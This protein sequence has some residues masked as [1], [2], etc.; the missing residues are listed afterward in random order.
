MNVLLVED[1]PGDAR[2]LDLMLQEALPDYSLTHA[3]SL[4]EAFPLVREGR[5]DVILLD[6]SLPDAS[7]HQTFWQ[8]HSVAFSTPII[9]MTGLDDEALAAE[10][11]QAGAQ[12]FLV[13]GTVDARVLQRAMRYAIERKRAESQ[14]RLA[15]RVFES[16]MEGILI[17][18]VGGRI[19]AANDA[20]CKITGHAEGDIVGKSLG[21]LWEG[22]DHDEVMQVVRA[23][24]ENNGKWQGEACLR[25]K[26]GQ[27]FPAWLGANAVL[28]A[29]GQVTHWLIVFTD[30]SDL[31]ESQD[32]LQYLAYHD[33]LTHLP[34]RMLFQD[35]LQQAIA[36]T[37]RG[38]HGVAVM[39]L[40]LD[41]FKN[42][43]DT[44]GH[45]YGDRLLCLVA[46]RVR[47]CVRETDTV[48]RLGGDEFALVLTFINHD[49][50]AILV[51]EKLIEALVPPFQ[52][53]QHEVFISTSIG[54]S[55]YWPG[56]EH[57]SN[58]LEEADVAMYHA[59]SLG[60]NGYQI[61]V[62]ELDAVAYEHL[63]MET[64]MRY[65]LERDEFKL[66][67]QPQ[68]A[69]EGGRVTAV[70][71]LL[72]WLSPE[73]GLVPPD[74]FIPLLEETGL[75]VPVGEWVIRTACK[76]A[77][78]WLDADMPTRVAVN[79][80]GRQFKQ[81]NLVQTVAKAL[82]EHQLPPHL[83]ELEITETILMDRVEE[84]IRQLHELKA[85][86][87]TIALDD[88]GSGAS[89]LGYLKDFPVDSVKICQSFVLNLPH[90]DDDSAIA[91]AVLGLAQGMRLT[92]VAEGVENEAQANFLKER[93][94][95]YLQGYLFSK[96]VPPEELEHLLRGRF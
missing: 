71:A 14:L 37:T 90:S 4:S 55:F 91:S 1:N 13:K 72:R 33:P 28:D 17:V 52:L 16:T 74:E 89:S 53:D 77:K 62:P 38:V 69:V 10:L 82:Q 49:Q 93:R 27:L 65:A 2:L 84:N 3:A 6:L 29:H 26:S 60:R 7:G 48:A 88:F 61:Y 66:Y 24:L 19:A 40:D 68:V 20:F 34:N 92:S 73:R 5:F 30:I 70:E 46:E 31:K 83:L 86:G 18:E 42:I 79:L 59:K 45:A 58:I 8:L 15:A 11:A 63:V 12:D 43:N 80:S 87:V 44:L 96:A 39:Y 22:G 94:C 35:R 32:R 54:I 78:Q 85:L 75:I 64:N 36:Q 51:A 25:R 21:L 57:K 50:D 56:Q 95:D 81:A 23:S 47:E 41:R 9:V 67:Y 76:Q